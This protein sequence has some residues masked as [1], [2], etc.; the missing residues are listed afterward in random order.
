M[1]KADLYWLAGLLEGEG[2]FSTTKWKGKLKTYVYPRV[3][4]TSTDRDVV[5]RAA[6]LMG[7]QVRAKR[8]QRAHYKVPYCVQIVSKQAAA[9]MREV[10]PHMGKRRSARIHQLLKEAA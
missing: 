5:V 6:A 3:D 2:C 8:P 10:L 4:M 9:I 1:K 7:G